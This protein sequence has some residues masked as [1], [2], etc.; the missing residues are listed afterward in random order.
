L[1]ANKVQVPQTY[2]SV[3]YSKLAVVVVVVVL[4]VVVVVG[5]GVVVVVVVLVVVVV[6]GIGVVVVVVVLVVG[7]NKQRFISPYT[8]VLS[9]T[10]IY[11][12]NP[13]IS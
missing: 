1:F 2:W 4:V 10:Y 7:T 8:F 3:K 9:T 5:I 13:I 11:V 6:V 12:F